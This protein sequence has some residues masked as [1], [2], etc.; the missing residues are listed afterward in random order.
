MDKYNPE[1]K[2]K[3]QAIASGWQH[4]MNT[5]PIFADGLNLMDRTTRAVTAGTRMW[6]I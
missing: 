2:G 6:K 4:L 5:G 1:G 3:Y